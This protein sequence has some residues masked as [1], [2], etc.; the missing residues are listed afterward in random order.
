M[1]GLLSGATA[2]QIGYRPKVGRVSDWRFSRPAGVQLS[3]VPGYG[4]EACLLY[5]DTGSPTPQNC[6]QSHATLRALSGALFAYVG[7]N[8]EQKVG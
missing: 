8:A 6:A 7:L 1:A 5:P 2:Q 4:G 3:P